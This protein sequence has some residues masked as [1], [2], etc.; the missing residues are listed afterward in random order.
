MLRENTYNMRNFQEISNENRKTVKYGIETIPNRTP[1]LWAN[2][3]SEYKLTISLH[4][5]K[6]KKN[7]WHFVKVIAKFS[8]KFWV[9]IKLLTK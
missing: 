7:N 2:L 1:F 3:L 9:F 6:L 5:F 4:D 8:A